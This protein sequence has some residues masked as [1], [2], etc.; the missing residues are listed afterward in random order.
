MLQ[1]CHGQI[2]KMKPDQWYKLISL[3][4]LVGG[5]LISIGVWKGK[6]TAN[7]T[8]F[9]EKLEQ[10]ITDKTKTDTRQTNDIEKLKDLVNQLNLQLTSLTS[11]LQ[12]LTKRVSMLDG[13][14]NNSLKV[15]V[16]T[17]AEQIQLTKSDLISKMN[18][19]KDTQ[20][21]ILKTLSFLQKKYNQQVIVEH[22]DP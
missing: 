19:I 21:G 16:K 15:E 7:N 4:I 12:D 6:Q 5:I 14:A 17:N 3:I 9:I 10:F 18:E 13:D 1:L 2:V 22:K 20:A 11:K 8:K